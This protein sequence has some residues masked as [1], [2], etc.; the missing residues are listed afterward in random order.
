MLTRSFQLVRRHIYVV[1]HAAEYGVL[2]TTTHVY[3]V[4]LVNEALFG[5]RGVS[6]IL[7]IIA[8]LLW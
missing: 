6:I 3:K 7:G 4:C 5:V 2:F 8:N 1:K